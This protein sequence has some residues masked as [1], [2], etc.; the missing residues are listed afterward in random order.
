MDY[1]K[2]TDVPKMNVGTPYEDFVVESHGLG[3]GV[4]KKELK[5]VKTLKITLIGVIYMV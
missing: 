3:M 2:E 5:R 4:A 1:F